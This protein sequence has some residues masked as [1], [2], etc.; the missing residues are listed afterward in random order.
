MIGRTL[1]TA[2]L[3]ISLT[4]CQDLLTDPPSERQSLFFDTARPLQV[5]SLE[6][7]F[8]SDIYTNQQFTLNS[9]EE[10]NAFWED[11]GS[12]NKTPEV[13]FDRATV[14]AATMGSRRTGGYVVEITDVA[15]ESGAIK[16]KVV[17]TS[18]GKCGTI[19]VITSPYHVVKIDTVV[20]DVEFVVEEHVH[21]CE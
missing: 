3:L 8:H 11:H 16:A 6:Q 19:Q 17:E 4:A 20:S 1:A 9:Q 10:L 12:N 21:D 5:D 14:L 13:D 2:L 15:V 18:P 7:G